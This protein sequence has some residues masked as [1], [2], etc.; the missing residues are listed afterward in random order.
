MKLEGQGNNV[1]PE[2]SLPSRERGLKQPAAL[3]RCRRRASLPSRERGLKR[4]LRRV[5]VDYTGSLPSRERGLKLLARV[6]IE[7]V[8]EVAPFT[9]A[10]IE[11]REALVALK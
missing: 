5:C 10:W 11:T 8:G 1:L 3:T 6:A 2:W 7:P 9:G 4:Y